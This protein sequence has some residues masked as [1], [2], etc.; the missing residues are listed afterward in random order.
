MG[1]WV[2][3]IE[4][5]GIHDNDRPDDADAMLS[6]FAGKLAD[7]GHQVHSA[8]IT[9][10]STKELLNEDDTTPLARTETGERCPLKYRHRTH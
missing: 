6:E 9:A 7:A 3:H 2:M 10:G 5:G 1:H 4:G 8:T